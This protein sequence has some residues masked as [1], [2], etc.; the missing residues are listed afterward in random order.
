MRLKLLAGAL[1]AGFV[2]APGCRA[3]D[4]GRSAAAGTDLRLSPITLASA[5]LLPPESTAQDKQPLPGPADLRPQ[6]SALSAAPEQ[7]VD[8]AGALAQAGVDNPT[9]ALA[10]EAVSAS[11][12]LH[13]QAQALLLPTLSAGGDFNWHQG[14]L[15]GAS[16]DT[17][18]VIRQSA[19]VG[20][21][22]SAVGGGTV[23]VPG[24]RLSA[25][26][27]EAL[28]EP[29]ATR[30]A[31]A[32]R[33][34]DAQATHNRVLLE[35][36]T[37]YF[38]LVGAEARLAAQRESEAEFGEIARLT[39]NH[40]K[41][42]QGRDA[43][44]QRAR[45]E[46]QLL[47]VAGRRIEEEIAVASAELT[48]LLSADPTAR[49]RGP[50]GPIPQL[51]LIDPDAD[52]ETLVQTALDNRP[53]IAAR[54]ADVAVVETRLRKEQVRPF[55]PTL[56]VGFSAG[57]FGGGGNTADTDF[58]HFRGRTDFDVTA[59]W[60]LQGLG[61]DN[62]ALQ[63]RMRAL[64][65]ETTAERLRVIDLVRTEVADAY[66]LVAARRN[67]LEVARRRAET[68][69]SAYQQDLRAAKTLDVLPIVLLNSAT[70][71][72]A[73]RQ[74]YLRALVGYNQAQL[75]LFVAIGQSP[76]CAGPD[77]RQP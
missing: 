1:L 15:Q 65:G 45:S 5:H 14:N 59:F 51:Q 62:L 54:A 12:A 19:Y 47:R 44:A 69:Q 49:L 22:A 67:E 41:A 27:G 24:V 53:E 72:N 28:F 32:G 77:L 33:Q 70:L 66:A 18:D 73:A 21:G 46:L 37:A 34:F 16:G 52:L 7:S 2:A 71:L 6:S 8:L 17:R 64:V 42:G 58:G 50:G 60:T 30:Q 55:V 20:A 36:G 3:P 74:D 35:V 61:L 11:Q 40:A 31:I 4:G 29:R 10:Q 23:N 63:R 25:Q 38:A 75:L 43:D 26:L 9:I 76:L 13:L 56:S 39:A 57:G 48:K 68:A